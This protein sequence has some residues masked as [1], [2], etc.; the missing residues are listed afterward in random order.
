MLKPMPGEKILDAGCGTGLFTRELIQARSFVTGIELSLPML[1]R[2]E[3]KLDS[4]LFLKVL[5]DMSDLPFAADTF[6]KVMSVTAIEF[7]RDARRAIAEL[8]RVTKP[9]GT[10]VV[11]SLNQKSPWAERRKEKA[12]RGHALFK[13]AIFRS[14]EE[15]RR[16][17]PARGEIKTA[18]HFEKHQDP[19]R[20]AEIEAKGMIS[21]RDTGAFIAIKWIK[22]K[23]E[24]L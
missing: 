14:P 22:D 10:I 1:L 19:A 2:A 16:L 9:A 15:L 8:F 13:S 4:S 21:G 23:Q 12:R 6:D 24:A 3:E 18:I 7:I 20:A 5:G 11:A 17:S